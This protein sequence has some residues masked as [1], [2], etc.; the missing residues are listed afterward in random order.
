[1]QRKI[2]GDPQQ[3]SSH[4]NTMTNQKYDSPKVMTFNSQTAE[5]TRD[6]V[7]RFR[8]FFESVYSLPKPNCIRDTEDN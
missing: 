8:S 1:M 2:A 5:T 4:V 7:H 6:I 3:F